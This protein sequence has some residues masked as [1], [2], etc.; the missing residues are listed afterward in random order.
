[1]SLAVELYAACVQLDVALAATRPPLINY[2]LA[3]STNLFVLAARLYPGQDATLRAQ[4]I[5]ALNRIPNPF[6]IPAGTVLRLA[7][8]TAS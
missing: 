8:P 7:R 5:L 2:T 4:D 6:A 3:G 1:M